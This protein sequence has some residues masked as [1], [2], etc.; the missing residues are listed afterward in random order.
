[1]T[2]KEKRALQNVHLF[3]LPTYVK[4]WLKYGFAVKAS[5][6]HVTNANY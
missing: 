2:I 5:R 6:Q 3:I 1:M 4:P